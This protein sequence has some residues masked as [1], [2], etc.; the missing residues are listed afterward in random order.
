MTSLL[1]GR[2]VRWI[3]GIVAVLVLIFAALF[4]Y[5]RPGGW[6]PISPETAIRRFRESTRN[7]P[8]SSPSATDSTAT[9]G[10]LP[11]VNSTSS[12][13]SGSVAN[14][15]PK[16]TVSRSLPPEGVYVYATKGGDSIDVLGG[17]KHE[18]PSRTTITVQHAGCGVINRWDALE[19]R[20]DKWELCRESSGYEIHRFQTS[21]EFFRSRDTREFGCS[22]LA[23]PSNMSRGKTWTY[24]CISGDITSTTKNRVVGQEEL[25]IGGVRVNTTHIHLEVEVSGEQQGSSTR[26]DWVTDDGLYV[27]QVST[28]DIDQKAPIGGRMHYHEHFETQLQSLTPRT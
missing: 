1:A 21:H 23:Y 25:S 18:Y 8:D 10:A 15:T 16:G 27:R 12:P 6:T 24:R 2:K 19:E 9:P 3:G 7:S 11:P 13:E 5:L 17:S 22:G 20:W 14:S 28:T 26:D 4:I